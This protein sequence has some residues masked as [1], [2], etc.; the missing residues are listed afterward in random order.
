MNS[1]TR[2]FDV[3]KNVKVIEWLKAELV[4]SVAALLK[5]MVKGSEGLILECLT[6]ILI[7]AYILGKRLGISYSRM[8]MNMKAHLRETIETEHEMEKWY[9]DIS[10]LLKYMEDGKR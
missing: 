8:D 9:G 2:E 3:A 10:S 4:S 7:T 6:A 1:K 5:A